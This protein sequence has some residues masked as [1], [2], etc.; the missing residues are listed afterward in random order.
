LWRL[1]DEFMVD[2]TT[3]DKKLVSVEARQSPFYFM[4]LLPFLALNVQKQQ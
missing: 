1:Q 2:Q 3:V 4:F